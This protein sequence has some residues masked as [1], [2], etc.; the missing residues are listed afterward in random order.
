MSMS[1]FSFIGVVFLIL[2]LIIVIIAIQAVLRTYTNK[3]ALIELKH[4]IDELE[5]RMNK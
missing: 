2:E 4:R 5:N 1:S 3:R